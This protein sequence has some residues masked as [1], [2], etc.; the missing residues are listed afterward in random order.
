MGRAQQDRFA[1][2]FGES[3]GSGRAYHWPPED[4]ERLCVVLDNDPVKERW[5]FA[6]SKSGELN[7]VGKLWC[8]TKSL[9]GWVGF[10]V[11]VW[12]S[13]GSRSLY[14]LLD[15]VTGKAAVWL[16]SW[17]LKGGVEEKV[18]WLAALMDRKPLPIEVGNSEN[19]TTTVAHWLG[20][21]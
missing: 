15:A 7:M 20:Y 2:I 21:T 6:E 16:V 17:P 9:E 18:R 5:Q 11:Q 8:E 13:E 3:R 4:G 12:P 1:S 19:G 14:E 10:V